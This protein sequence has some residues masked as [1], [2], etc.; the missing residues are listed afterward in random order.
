M[1]ILQDVYIF[2]YRRMWGWIFITSILLRLRL[3]ACFKF[4]NTLVQALTGWW[5][6]ALYSLVIVQSLS[7][8]LSLSL[9]LVSLSQCFCTSKSIIKM[10]NGIVSKWILENVTNLKTLDDPIKRSKPE[11][12]H[13]G[14][15]KLGAE[16]CVSPLWCCLPQGGSGLPLCW[17]KIL[18]TEGQIYGY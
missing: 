9:S 3:E 12:L 1:E 7:V 8:P 5:V 18:G 10:E 17:E 13:T 14:P 4:K 2:W 15:R 11:C 6:L 16:G